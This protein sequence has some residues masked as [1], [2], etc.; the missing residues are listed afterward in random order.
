MKIAVIGTGISGLSAAWLLSE[1]HDVTIYEKED[2]IGGHTHTVDLDYDGKLIAVDTGFI[3]YNETNYP[4]LTALFRELNVP[5]EASDMSFGFSGRNHSV[6]W[7]SNSLKTVFAQKRNIA[8]P[9][10]LLMLLGILR[11]NR[12]AVGDITAAELEGVT[13]GEYLSERGF[14]SRFRDHYLLPMGSAIWSTSMEEM[15]Q[16]PAATFLRFFDNHQLLA[17]PSKQFQ[18][19]TVTGGSREYV[20]RILEQT[21]ARIRRSTAV[22]SV[23]RKN[24]QVIVRD[25]HGNID[26]FQHVVLACHSDESLSLLADPSPAER[27]VLGGIR[28]APNL[29]IL[30]RDS[31]LMPL[32]SKVWSSWNYMT[33]PLDDQTKA[34]PSVTYWMNRLQNIDKRY[35]LF[36]SLNPNRLPAQDLTFAQFNYMHPQFD[37]KAVSS[38]RHIAQIQG[39]RNTWYCGAWCG[40]GFHEDGLSSGLAVA[41]QFGA[42]RPWAKLDGHAATMTKPRGLRQ[43]A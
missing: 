15:L 17:P 34:L 31:T 41:E 1:K 11:F 2:R 9:A 37:M 3:V 10:F 40:Y 22:T 36:V 25:V 21:R 42:G 4:N 32:R 13:L 27:D 7:S 33:A 20:N 5:T 38:Q 26:R 35:P 19:H 6:E 14:G 28:Y 8:N 39:D 23:E 18:W 29:A 12:I 16:F 24:G 43:A 30:H